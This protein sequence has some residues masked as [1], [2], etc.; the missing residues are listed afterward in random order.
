MRT[1][2][3]L[4]TVVA[5]LLPRF[6]LAVAVGSSAA[7]ARGP[8]ALAP[9]PGGAQAVGEV[10]AGAEAFGVREGMG[11]GEALA[12]CPTLALVPPDPA[13]VAEAWEVLL[14]RLEGIGAAVAP[15]RPGLACFRAD[16]LRALHGGGVAEVVAA[17]ARALRRPARLGA[18]PTAFCALA[19]ATRARPRRPELVSGGAGE[20]RAYL[21]PLP[22]DLLA[23]RERTAALPRA[24]ERFG[25]RRLGE[26]AALPRDAVADRFG[27]AGLHAHALALGGDGPLVARRSPERLAESLE[28]PEAASGPQLDHALALLVDRLVARRERRG[29][30]LRAVVLSAVLV[31][32]GTWH[33]RVAFRQALADPARMRLALGRRLALLP[34]PAEAL[35]LAVESFGPPVT[36]QRPLL[37][38]A[39]AARRARLREAVRQ[40]RALAGTD[41]ALRVVEIEPDSRVPERRAMLAPYEEGEEA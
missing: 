4:V 22:V 29:R 28:L 9:A 10:S 1:C 7:L 11:L 38:E 33:E 13:G 5:V 2:V 17:A 31:E 3:R 15:E 16:G 20:A 12:R 25:L 26:L 27:A 18:G 34:A 32:G 6:Q 23:L 35:R 14:A 40:A 41:A 21:A 36:D 39:A 8:A 24:L 30:T 19:A 37:D